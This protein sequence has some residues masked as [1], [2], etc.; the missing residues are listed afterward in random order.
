MENKE[1]LSEPKGDR[2][3]THFHVA[4]VLRVEATAEQEARVLRKIDL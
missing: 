4:D 3:D 1:I 2:K